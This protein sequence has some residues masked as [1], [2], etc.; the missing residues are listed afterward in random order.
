MD[1]ASFFSGVTTC[2]DS[3]A[4]ISTAS[5]STSRFWTATFLSKSMHFTAISPAWETS[6]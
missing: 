3:T 6:N 1:D 2:F 5:L 4:L